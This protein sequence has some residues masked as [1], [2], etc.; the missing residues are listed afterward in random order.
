M[1]L[2]PPV[3][4]S[5]CQWEHN[6]QHLVLLMQA[7]VEVHTVVRLE[8]SCHL[9]LILSQHVMDMCLVTFDP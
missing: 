7:L 5:M 1:T 9:V 2:Q 8:S 6:V 3:C 4:T